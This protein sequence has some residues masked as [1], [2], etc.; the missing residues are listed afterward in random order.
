MIFHIDSDAFFASCE[1]SVKPFLKN[2][3]VVVGLERGVVTAVCYL[4]KQLGVERGMRIREIKNNFPQVVI[5]R[6]NYPLYRLISKRMFDILRQFT[7]KIEEYS[8]DEAF[9]DIIDLDSFYSS[10]YYQLG[11]KIQE[12]IN[13][14]LDISVSIGISLTKVLAKIASKYQKPRGLTIIDKNQINFYLQNTPIE[15]VWGI[16]SANV[17]V[18]SQLGIKT[19]F[20]LA[21]KSQ[22]WVKKHFYKPQL[23]IWHELRGESI[24]A[25]QTEKKPQKS[26]IRSY[27][28]YPSINQFEKIKSHLYHNIDL[29]FFQLRSL[30]LLTKKM[31]IFLK[32]RLFRYHSIEIKLEKATAYPIE[33]KE[34]IDNALRKAFKKGDFYRG[35]GVVLSGLS[36]INYY[37]INFFEDKSAR[38][39][40]MNLYQSIDKIYK[41]YGRDKLLNGVE[42]LTQRKEKK[43]D[44]SWPVLRIKV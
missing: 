18:M 12:K 34:L 22:S 20:D 32:N 10:S 21:Q 26:I 15:K 2:K 42:I 28:F 9:L 25:V 17:K 16:G 19:A 24:F 37:Q 38:K 4:A 7:E 39:R 13:K 31:I 14:E 1:K 36:P 11:K 29:A 30:N 27:T 35:T 8:I 33:I 43:I 6:S 3:P 5:C 40:L 44:F 41:K 23:E